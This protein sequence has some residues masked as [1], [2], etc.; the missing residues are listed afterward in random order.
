MN[1]SGPRVCVVIPTKNEENS[2]AKVI[3]DVKRAIEDAGFGIPLVVVTDDSVDGT[4]AAAG[5][6]GATVVRAGGIGLGYAMAVG[7]RE[8]VR[9]ECEYIVS[10]DGDGQA[11]PS[12]IPAFLEPLESGRADLVLGSRFLAKGLVKYKYPRFNRVGVLILAWL[13]TLFS[14]QRFTDSHG[15]IRAMRRQV[16][17]ELALTGTH[18]YVQETIIDAV[19]RGYRVTEVPSAWT[20]R[21]H[22]SSRVVASIPRYAA[23]TLPVLLV[24]TGKHITWLT[25]GGAFFA[26]AAV[27][28]FVAILIEEGF[29]IPDLFDRLPA[30]LLIALLVMVGTQMFFTGLVLEM[31][32]NMARR[33][34]RVD[35]SRQ[36]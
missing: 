32:R 34:D 20:K 29:S 16:V 5:R 21:E 35:P 33:V 1:P 31:L 27:V 7:L 4:E 3:D 6:A 26:V 28:G 18:S 14:G 8:A 23:H 24:K 12:E 9:T 17:A 11:D 15:G 10:V 30:L 13:L 22:G 36:D 25:T 19:Q 2:I